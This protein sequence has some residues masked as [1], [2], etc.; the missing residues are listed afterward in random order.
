MNI[1]R[2]KG[3]SGRHGGEHLAGSV[4]ANG[5]RIGEKGIPM[6]FAGPALRRPELE[7][8]EKSH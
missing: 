7:H 1:T 5:F 2:G 6:A 3:A 4:G 8:Y